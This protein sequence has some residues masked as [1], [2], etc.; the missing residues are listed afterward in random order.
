MSDRTYRHED[1]YLLSHTEEVLMIQ[2]ALAVMQRDDHAGPDGYYR[3]R[4]LYFDDNTDSCYYDT[5][6]GNDPRSK[7]R[8]RIYD[9]DTS[10]IRLEKKI[11]NKGLTRK[12]SSVITKDECEAIIEGRYSDILRASSD[13]K[14]ELIAEMQIKGLRPVV[15]VSYD[16]Y[17][18]IYPSLG[19]RFTID[20]NLCYETDAH[21]FLSDAASGIPVRT[22]GERIMELKWNNIM[23]AHLIEYFRIETLQKDRFS[24]YYTCRSAAMIAP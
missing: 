22:S 21:T 8:I 17:P 6:S 12:V 15:T 19:I 13:L 10:Y 16:R 23:P 14:G 5:E 18:F 24:K 9:R 7:F 11:K 1:K 2:R 3:I 4:S 20:S